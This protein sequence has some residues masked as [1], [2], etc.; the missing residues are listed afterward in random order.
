MRT[1]D[2][3][4]GQRLVN[5][6]WV[7][8]ALYSTACENLIVLLSSGEHSPPS[9]MSV[10][11]DTDSAAIFGTVIGSIISNLCKLPHILFLS[12]NSSSSRAVFILGMSTFLGGIHFS[13]QSLGMSAYPCVCL[14]LPYLPD[15]S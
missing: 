2:T 7:L 8:Y 3:W 1:I 6:M 9:A 5:Q 12:Y 4:F 14:L 10:S 15:L 11:S 13:E